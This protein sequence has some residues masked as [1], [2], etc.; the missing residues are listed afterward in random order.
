MW[1]GL[2]V[3]TDSALSLLV[4]VADALIVPRFRHLHEDQVDEKN[5]GDL[6]TVADTEAEE[7][8]TQALLED[9]PD[10]VVV[11]E[12]AVSADPSLL[13]G[14]VHAPRAWVIDPVDG[15]KNFVNGSSDHAV[16]LA[17]LRHGRPVRSWIWQ[18][19]YRRS[20]VAE[21]GAGVEVDGRPWTR[22]RAAAPWQGATSNPTVLASEAPGL[23]KSRLCCGV[24]Y[25][26]LLTG[27]LDYL[28]YAHSHPWDHAPG[29]LLVRE[30]GGV[31]WGPNRKDYCPAD[32]CRLIVAA[33][34][35]AIAKDVFNQLSE[36]L[37]AV[38]AEAGNRD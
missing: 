20:F 30:A 14:L 25:P 7:A 22:P 17:E 21:A 31:S 33:G 4:T 27:E 19:Q 37:E 16:M 18:P 9:D 11:G 8:I 3:Q 23:G 1:Q 38:A 29:A 34:R 2:P 32:P 28:V 5:P 15:T 13:K 6:V 26:M 36:P 35:P 10:A 24:D 12:E